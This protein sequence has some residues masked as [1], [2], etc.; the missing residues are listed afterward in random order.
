[1][2][3]AHST[4]TTLIVKPVFG[5]SMNSCRNRTNNRIKPLKHQKIDYGSWNKWEH[6]ST[7]NDGNWHISWLLFRCDFDSDKKC[8]AGALEKCM[9]SDP[10]AVIIVNVMVLLY[11]SNCIQTIQHQATFNSKNVMHINGSLRYGNG[12]RNTRR[13]TPHRLLM[14]CT[15]CICMACIFININQRTA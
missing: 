1:M 7:I 9:K 6:L 15:W 13:K 2:I 8:Y 14:H 5:L 4:F 3:T 11:L 10:F 12:E